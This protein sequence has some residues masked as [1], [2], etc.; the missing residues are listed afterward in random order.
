MRIVSG[1][2]RS[3]NLKSLKGDNT[4]PTSDKIRA[5][6][7]DSIAFDDY[8]Y[9]TMLD[10]FSGSGAMGLEAISRGFSKVVFNDN[11]KAAIRI[12]K[13][14]INDLKV[15][16]KTIV[17]GYDYKHTLK[18]MEDSAIDLIFIDPPYDKIDLNEI[19][20]LISDLN[21]LSDDGIIIV[22]GSNKLDLAKN[23]EDFTKYKEK[24][25]KATRIMYFKKG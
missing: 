6:I 9:Q 10:L 14:N 13:E 18:I 1:E 5:A 20:K 11:N 15:K 4:R 16:D 25:Y 24:D 19:F 7:F 8:K 17:Y 3:R 2:F 22:E 21:V 23:I 12:I